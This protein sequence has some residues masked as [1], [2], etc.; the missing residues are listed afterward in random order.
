MHGVSEIDICE[1]VSAVT[2]SGLPLDLGLAADIFTRLAEA[3]V[4]IDMVSQTLPVGG[5]VNI[6]FTC[7][8]KDLRAMLEVTKTLGKAHPGVSSLVNSGNVK[9]Q[10]FGEEM[11]GQ[12]GVFARAI[13]ALSAADVGSPK[14]VTT[15]EVDISFLVPA[16]DL[17]KAKAALAAVFEI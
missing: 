6:S 12:P 11:V 16:A 14:L 2:L 3:M 4:V 1:D 15:S 10:L 9:I 13:S 5:R 8:D 7:R 17:P